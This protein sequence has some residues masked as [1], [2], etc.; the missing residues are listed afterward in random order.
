MARGV[1]CHPVSPGFRRGLFGRRDLHPR[2]AAAKMYARSCVQ[3]IF[4]NADAIRELVRRQPFA[5]FVIRLSSGEAHE[6]RH[7]E[8]ILV[9]KTRLVIT[10]PQEDRI[11]VCSLMHVTSVDYLQP[12]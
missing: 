9:T 5:P 12:T 7:P 8:C 3:E 11:A 4:M 10:D 1:A 2:D 6:V